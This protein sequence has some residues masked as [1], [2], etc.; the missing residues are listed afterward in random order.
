MNYLAHIFLAGHSE[1]AMLGALLGDFV[2]PGACGGYSGEIEQEIVMHRKVDAYTD[3]HRVVLAAKRCFPESRRRYAG[4]LLDVF[5]DHLLAAHWASYSSEPLHEFTRRFYSALI[6]HEHLLPAN[7]AAIAPRLS[8][9]GDLL[10]D[11]LRDLGAN[12]SLLSEGFAVFFPELMQFVAETRG[13]TA[14]P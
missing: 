12:Y 14:S 3:S 6:R 7:L 10:R 1:E 5:Y 8:R 13:R 4:I 11:G 2:K 9:N